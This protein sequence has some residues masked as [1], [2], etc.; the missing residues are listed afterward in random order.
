M[1]TPHTKFY[2]LLE[3]MPDFSK[4]ELVQRYSR[5]KTSS[6]KEFLNINPEGYERM[7]K[8]MSALVNMHQKWHDAEIKKLRSGVLHRMQKYGIDTSNWNEVNRF[9]EQAQLGGKRLYDFNAK[10]LTQLISRMEALLQKGKTAKNKANDEGIFVFHS[11]NNNN[12]TIN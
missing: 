2:A 4:E 1:K 11:N 10:E 3:L 7:I 12:N 8:D 5:F 9:L 6:L